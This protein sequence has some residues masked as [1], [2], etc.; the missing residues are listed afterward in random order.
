MLSAPPLATGPLR[1]G[2]RSALGVGL[3]LTAVTLVFPLA[4]WATTIRAAAIHLVPAA[5]A[6][7]LITLLR[8]LTYLRKFRLVRQDDDDSVA[9][10]DTG[11]RAQRRPGRRRSAPTPSAS[12]TRSARAGAA[13]TRWGC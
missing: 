6:L 2:L 12:W 3:A 7:P 1:Q 13:G 9:L 5:P 11:Q 10:T 4:P 8:A